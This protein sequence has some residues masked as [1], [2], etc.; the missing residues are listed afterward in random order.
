MYPLRGAGKQE[1][2]R[3]ES[4]YRHLEIP[5]PQH[6][7]KIAKSLFSRFS[8]SVFVVGMPQRG[9]AI[10]GCKLIMCANW[11][12]KKSC[13]KISKGNTGGRKRQLG[14]CI[15]YFYGLPKVA[16]LK[17]VCSSVHISKS[18]RDRNDLLW[19]SVFRLSAFRLQL[20][21]ENRQAKQKDASKK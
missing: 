6:K 21:P 19:S 8:L 7:R 13:V 12:M 5:T 11:S 14:N 3:Q 20:A 4:V 10:C 2:P 17:A 15:A 1:H 18:P 16:P 9:V